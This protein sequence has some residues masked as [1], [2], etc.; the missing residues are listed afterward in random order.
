MSLDNGAALEVRNLTLR[1]RADDPPAVDD[2][3]FEARPGETLGLLGPNGAGK[4]TIVGVCTT[5]LRADAGDAWV[6][7]RSVAH[8]GRS[9][10]RHLG[11][12]T[13]HN[14]LD[15]SC[16]VA[17]NLYYHCRFFGMNRGRARE[18]T[19][20]LLA[21]FDLTPR[22]GHKPAWLSG[23]MV[24]R[25]QLARAIAH[26]PRLLFLDE[27]SAGLDPQSRLAMWGQL[28]R[29]RGNG[30]TIL[31]TTHYLEEAERLCDRIA[32]LDSGRL[33]AC[34]TPP[35]LARVAGSR[36]RIELSVLR[37]DDA[38]TGRL[39]AIP[40]VLGVA[41][42]GQPGTYVLDTDGVD[43]AVAAALQVAGYAG[44][45][46]LRVVAPSL[47]DVFLAMTGRNVRE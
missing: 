17:Q 27:P 41:E 5:R 22:A 19:A 34:A 12:V 3:S 46:G 28:R 31:L 10:R 16:T 35:E 47:E 1:Y 32:V 42:P 6:A 15:R 44:V 45:S 11:V 14:T 38:L 13:Q 9:A 26:E 36:T 30:T 8:H 43:E 7:G 23:G 29:L 18:R 2:V 21:E 4:S 33:L 39:Q 24:Q 25:L 40:A 37:P 20:E